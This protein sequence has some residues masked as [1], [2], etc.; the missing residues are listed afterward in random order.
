[1]N[2][3]FFLSLSLLPF[4]LASCFDGSSSSQGASAGFLLSDASI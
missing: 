4:H 2:R 3:L 1:M